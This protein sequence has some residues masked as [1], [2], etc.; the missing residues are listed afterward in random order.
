MFSR[1]GSRSAHR[2]R[3]NFLGPAGPAARSH[4]G[5]GQSADSRSAISWR[6]LRSQ[7]STVPPV[8]VPVGMPGK[9]L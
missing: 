4:P 3:Q 9:S 1:R 2:R 7:Q 6:Q 8:A 5:A